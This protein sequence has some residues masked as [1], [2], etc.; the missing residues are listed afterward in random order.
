MDRGTFFAINAYQEAIQQAG[1]NLTSIDPTRISVCLGSSHCGLARTEDVIKGVLD[2]NLASMDPKIIAATLVHHCTSVIKR[3]SGARGPVLTISSACASSNSA[4]GVGADLIRKGKSDIVIA[5]GSDTVSLSVMAGFNALRAISSSKTA[6]FSNPVGLNI[7]EGAGIVIL[8]RTDFNV[9]GVKV[10]RPI[11]EVL[12]YGLSGDAYHATSP[13]TEGVGAIQAM[14]AALE[15]SGVDATD[16][17]YV[18]A[19]G[20]GTEAN[21]SAESIAIKK[22][23]GTQTPVSSTKSYMG[24]TLGASG[25]LELISTLLLANNGMVP[26]GLRMTKVRQGCADLD[27]VR[28]EPRKGIYNAIMVNNFGFGGN[29]SSLVVSPANGHVSRSPIVASP[30]D[31]VITGIGTMSAVGAGFEA[32]GVAL[33]TGV[34]LSERDEDCG[35]RLANCQK[36]SF[37]D[38]Q[39]R[40]FARSAPVIKYSLTALREAL[41][42][43]QK[44]YH[45]NSRSGL[46]SGMVFGAQKPTE[47]YME[48]V[49]VADP[50][51]A[52]AH[53]F[54]MITMNAT[55]GA[56]SLAFGVSG[57]TTTLC[58]SAA[59]LIYA[60]ELTRY[61]R[62]DR[63]IVV[64]GDELT[65]RL[66]KIYSRCGVVKDDHKKSAGRAG[67][68]GEFGVGFCLEQ[69]AQAQRRGRRSLACLTGWAHKQDPLDH[70]V[71]RDG[72]SLAD[73]I[74]S[75][76]KMAN[77]SAEGI[78]LISLLDH[79]L[80]PVN[81]ACRRAIN[82]VFGNNVPKIVRPAHVFGYAPSSGAMMMVAAAYFCLKQ[83][84]TKPHYALAAGYDLVCD[85][86]AFIVKLDE[87]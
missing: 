21:D 29:N 6:P 58:G 81:R 44:I 1:I 80:A 62:Q 26:H 60:A 33:S 11:A 51:F 7:G 13:D 35:V 82:R 78:G 17:D 46:I 23:F 14:Q 56:C 47:K 84:Q 34:D 8:V 85:G 66:A 45:R 86:F 18:N 24:H 25:V 49:F 3:L 12:G 63:M 76:L 64:S 41:G 53:F 16:I 39:F 59:S 37:D 52:N 71:S 77:I 22:L 28:D 69:A 75:A 74:E 61:N 9:S 4:I 38:T 43:D 73:A 55:G 48:S 57:Y 32:F 27:Y 10:N 40:P 68:L 72:N 15:D 5:G 70:S 67:S 83:V 42:D 79:G 50:A 2:G 54:P 65:P 87:D 30:A 19:H 31:V 20:T 36:L